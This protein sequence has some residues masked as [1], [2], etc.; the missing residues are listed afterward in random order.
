MTEQVEQS[1]ST[2]A[3]AVYLAQV[4]WSDPDQLGHV[5][6]ARYL[7]YFEDARMEL[8]AGAPTGVP[9]S[10]ADR[11][12][13]AARVA[14]DYAAPVEFRPGLVLRVETEVAAIGTSSWTLAQ[15]MC[16]GERPVARCECVLVAYSYAESKPRPLDD[17]ERAYWQRFAVAG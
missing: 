13:I 4:R 14:V 17:D 8:L 5:N 16:D 10:P 6:H 3:P 11:G 1:E 2:S 9:G 12:C 15:R 7:S